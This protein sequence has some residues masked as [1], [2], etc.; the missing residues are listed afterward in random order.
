MV[1]MIV[2]IDDE[3]FNY[4]LF[5]WFIDHNLGPKLLTLRS[6]FLEVYLV[7]FTRQIPTRDA[8]DLLWRLYE[9]NGKFA[10]AAETLEWL[11]DGYDPEAGVPEGAA[12]PIGADQPVLAAGGG[13]GADEMQVDP[14]RQRAISLEERAQYLTR[15]LECLHNSGAARSVGGA[16]EA[17]LLAATQRIRDKLEMARVQC[18]LRDALL[19]LRDRTDP[20]NAE[21]VERLDGP[22]R[23]IKRKFYDNEAVFVSK[24]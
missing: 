24:V 10:L 15:A 1:D 17:K 2:A 11:A 6:R 18:S 14:R 4:T 23:D 16:F 19:A 7:R 9:K 20:T 22:L 8:A 3:L 12:A 21:Q 13:A 5:D